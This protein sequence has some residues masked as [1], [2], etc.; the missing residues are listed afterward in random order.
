MISRQKL[1]D[2]V[3]EIKFAL[4]VSQL[5]SLEER[6]QFMTVKVRVTRIYSSSLQ[7]RSF[8]L[9]THR[10]YGW[11]RSGLMSASSGIKKNMVIW[12]KFNW[13]VMLYGSLSLYYTTMQMVIMRLRITQTQLFITMELSNGHHQLFFIGEYTTIY[14]QI[15]LE[16]NNSICRYLIQILWMSNVP[17]FMWIY[18]CIPLLKKYTKNRALRH[19]YHNLAYIG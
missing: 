15:N 14:I 16:W 13:L 4:I 1:I 2:D 17:R 6:E 8:I 3:V 12:Q 9:V 11:H 10:R 5:I 19:I 7:I 18:M